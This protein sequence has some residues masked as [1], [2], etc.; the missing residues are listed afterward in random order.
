MKP[1]DPALTKVRLR[2]LEKIFQA[3]INGELPCQLGRH[4]PSEVAAMV[5]DGQIAPLNVT[6]PG[7]LPVVISGYVLTHRGRVLYCEDCA[8]K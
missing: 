1:R 7:R 3:E 6:L 8:R 5:E 4:N 2:I